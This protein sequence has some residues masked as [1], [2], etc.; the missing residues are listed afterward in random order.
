MQSVPAAGQTV[1]VGATAPSF[2]LAGPG[3]LDLF[4]QQI[5]TT[6]RFAGP[7][8]PRVRL[9]QITLNQQLTDFTHSASGTSAAQSLET[10]LVD[11]WRWYF[12]WQLVIVGGLAEAYVQGLKD[13]APFHPT[14]AGELAIAL[15]DEEALIGP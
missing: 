9:T 3:E 12:V 14:A 6:T 1:Q 7:V 13:R 10:A 4:G 5:P 2:S 11:G 8:R 15:A